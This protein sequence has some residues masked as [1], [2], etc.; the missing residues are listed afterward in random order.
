MRGTSLHQ[1]LK[2][3]GK[4][5]ASRP[6]LPEIPPT[7]LPRKASAVPAQLPSKPVTREFT[8]QQELELHAILPQLES[9]RFESSGVPYALRFVVAKGSIF[10]ATGYRMLGQILL[11]PPSLQTTV[12]YPKSELQTAPGFQFKC[13]HPESC[14]WCTLQ[15]S[16]V[17]EPA[18][19]VL[20]N[21]TMSKTSQ[22]Q[23]QL[24]G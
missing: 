10:V 18:L 23:G 17:E 7:V 8:G 2:N 22:M 20:D 11:T 14:C 12:I 1:P 16:K 5:A 3:P 19:V 21:V 24:G 13:H 15:Q 4:H 6:C 9:L